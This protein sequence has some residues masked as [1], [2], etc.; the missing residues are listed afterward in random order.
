MLGEH[1]N[2]CKF[3]LLRVRIDILSFLEEFCKLDKQREHLLR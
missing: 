2:M 3:K 1:C